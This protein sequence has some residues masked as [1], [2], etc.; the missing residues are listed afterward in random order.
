MSDDKKPFCRPKIPDGPDRCCDRTDIGPDFELGDPLG[1]LPFK[2]I[3]DIFHRGF[4]LPLFP[5]C[6]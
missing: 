4:V 2:F 6:R 3:P 5:G 1:L